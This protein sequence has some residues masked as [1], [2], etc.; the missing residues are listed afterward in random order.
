MHMCRL[1]L[2]IIVCMCISVNVCMYTH[3]CVCACMLL[4][5]VFMCG[6]ACEWI[7]GIVSVCTC[8]CIVALEWGVYVYM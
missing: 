7:K 4:V 8:M 2:Y 6:Y 3:D 1:C 5:S